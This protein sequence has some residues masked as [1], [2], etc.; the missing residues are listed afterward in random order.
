MTTVSDTKFTPTQQRLLA[1][2]EDGE[3]HCRADLLKC[4]SDD[5]TLPS[6]LRVHIC[7][8]R[9][10]LLPQGRGVACEFVAGKIHYRLFRRI[11]KD[12]S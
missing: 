1:I 7:L 8:L 11:S 10:R 9:K 6:T 3:P 5:L 2:L 12:D 4:L